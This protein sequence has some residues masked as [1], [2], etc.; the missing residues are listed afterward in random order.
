MNFYRVD[1]SI[2]VPAKSAQE[3]ITLAAKVINAAGVDAFVGTVTVLVG[4]QRN[5]D[6]FVPSR[7]GETLYHKSVV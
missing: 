2:G 6:E 4:D 5:D 7:D 1:F 3:A